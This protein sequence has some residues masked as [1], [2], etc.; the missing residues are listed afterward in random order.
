MAQVQAPIVEWQIFEKD[1]T[2]A[3][4]AVIDSQANPKKDA[5]LYS[6]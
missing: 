4:K 2:Q 3:R 1:P 6:L 5:W